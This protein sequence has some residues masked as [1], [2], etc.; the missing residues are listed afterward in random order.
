MK[1]AIFIVPLKINKK[2]VLTIQIL[3]IL[4]IF[5]VNFDSSGSAKVLLHQFHSF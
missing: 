1:I 5:A 3:F 4:Q 2:N